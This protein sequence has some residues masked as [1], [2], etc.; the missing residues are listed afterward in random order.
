MAD[1]L[2]AT[3]NLLLAKDDPHPLTSASNLARDLHAL[4]AR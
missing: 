3:P 4:T 1:T 2:T